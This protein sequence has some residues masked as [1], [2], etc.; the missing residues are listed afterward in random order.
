MCYLLRLSIKPALL[1]TDHIFT[2]TPASSTG[3]SPTRDVGTRQNEKFLTG[4]QSRVQNC[5]EKV[6]HISATAS[7]THV[8]NI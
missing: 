7:N 6:G 8:I 4:L 5:N 2:R 3:I 1:N